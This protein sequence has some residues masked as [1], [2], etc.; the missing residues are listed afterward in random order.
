MHLTTESK[1]LTTQQS[2]NFEE[3]PINRKKVNKTVGGS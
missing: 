1:R 3:D 2:E